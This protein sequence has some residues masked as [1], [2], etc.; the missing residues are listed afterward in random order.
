[1]E[2]KL[3]CEGINSKGFG[4]I[5][6]L[7]MQDRS[8][9]ATAKCI[10]AYFCSFAGAGAL[11]FPTRKKVC[12]DLGISIDTFGKYLKQLIERGYIKCEQFKENGRFSHNVYTLCST[13]PPCTKISDTENTVYDRLDTNN[14]N[15]NNNNINN[16]KSNNSKVSKASIEQKE[17]SSTDCTQQTYDEIIDEYTDN[18]DLK[19]ELKAFLQLRKMK[20]APL[21][22]RGL[23]LVL[24]TLD[25]LAYEDYAKIRIVQNALAS[26]STSFKALSDKE[27]EQLYLEHSIEQIHGKDF[28]KNIM[29]HEMFTA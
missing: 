17:K 11:C 6:K 21:I 9:H 28:L 19:K 16:N 29:N 8:I 20:N 13:I 26:G 5:P 25:K 14:N 2:D 1:M 10:Y 24:N 23:K 15:N 27:A 22:N 7:I 4:I 18:E 12:Y 3:I